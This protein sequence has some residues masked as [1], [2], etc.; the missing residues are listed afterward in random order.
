VA[1]P[2]LFEETELSL[3]EIIVKA[4]KDVDVL[5]AIADIRIEKNKEP[6]GFVNAAILV[7]RPGWVH[8]RIYKMGMLVRD[9]VIKDAELYVLSG[10]GGKNLKDL[11]SE[12]YNAVFWWDHMRD[13]VMRSEKDNYIIRAENKEIHI[14][15]ATLLPV[16]QTVSSSAAEVEI[17]YDRPREQE[18]GFWYQSEIQILVG[19]YKFKVKLK[20]LL[21]NPSLGELDFRIPAEG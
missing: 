12:F 8:M 13:G 9:F 10:K 1:A 5:K 11:G 6:F 4:G 16:K 2:P 15:R 18:N 20:K 21:R 19:E 17:A 3:E 14:D 7:K